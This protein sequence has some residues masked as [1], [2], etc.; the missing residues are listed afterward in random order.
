M[1]MIGG[2]KM[3]KLRNILGIMGVLVIA[4]MLVGCGKEENVTGSVTEIMDK[5]YAGIKDEEK[6]MMLTN[7]ELNEE[8]FE[9]FAFVKDV[10]YKEAVASESGVGS[11]AH[12]VVLIRLEN[13][14][15]ANKLVNDIKANANP[16]KWICVEAE[17]VIV[18]AKGDLVVLIMSNELASRIE[19]NFNN[20]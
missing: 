20:L 17:N 8:N 15:D 4:L 9:S 18:K 7:M 6:P 13:S 14:A 12:S 1:N 2:V 11:I 5:L 10:K 16:R 3:K 19:E